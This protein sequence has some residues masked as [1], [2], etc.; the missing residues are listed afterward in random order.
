VHWQGLK[1]LARSI[2]T[3]IVPLLGECKVRQ[4]KKRCGTARTFHFSK[5][6]LQE[7]I[8][9]FAPLAMALANFRKLQTLYSHELKKTFLEAEVPF[10]AELI[11]A[12]QSFR[13]ISSAKSRKRMN[14]Q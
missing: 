10:S 13:R 8:D 6:V 2:S 12:I 14:G 7:P 5:Y 11:G 1:E 3:K 9:I 4:L